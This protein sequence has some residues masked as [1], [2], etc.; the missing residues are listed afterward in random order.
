MKKK[1]MPYLLSY[2]F[3]IVSYLV[4]SFI[5]TILFSFIHVS[6]FVYQL[7]ITFFSY[8]TL[9]IFTFFFYKLI[10]E[11]P[12]IHV[13]ILSMTYCL[14]QLLFHL[15]DIHFSLFIKPLCLLIIYYLLYYINKKQQ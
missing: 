2:A 3:L 1:L 5:M 6:S 11:K 10:K 13:F 7:V 12:L 4:I 9:V 15:K 14:I 8:L